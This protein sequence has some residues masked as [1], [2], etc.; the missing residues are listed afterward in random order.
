M[1]VLDPYSS[2]FPEATP[3]S[4]VM[5]CAR[6]SFSN[7]TARQGKHMEASSLPFINDRTKGPSAES[8]ALSCLTV[9]SCCLAAIC[10]DETG[11]WR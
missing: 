3:H 11:H 8:M 10:Q 9:M 2:V 1:N 4:T 7:D 6:F 5:W